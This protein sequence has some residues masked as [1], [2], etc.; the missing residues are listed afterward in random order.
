MTAHGVLQ[1]KRLATY[2]AVRSSTIGPVQYVFASDLQRAADTAQAIVDAQISALANHSEV[3]GSPPLRVAKSAALRE[4]NFGSAEGK[5]FG[6]PRDDAETHDEMRVRAESFIDEHLDPLLNDL[7]RGIKPAAS[8]AVVSHGILLNSLLMALLMRYAPPEL[9]RLAKPGPAAG[10]P[11]YLASWSN[12][13]YVEA[14]IGSSSLSPRAASTGLTLPGPS[15]TANPMAPVPTLTIARV[16]AVDHL[17]GLKKTRGGIG[18][19]Q[20]DSRQRTVDSFFRPVA[21]DQGGGR[22]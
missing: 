7:V 3:F 22:C 13:G 2:L 18:S 11:A 1:A 19:A 4:R 10:Q 8:V 12:T 20:F 6:A 5:R 21:K 17:A 14:I 15:M 9:S 16:N